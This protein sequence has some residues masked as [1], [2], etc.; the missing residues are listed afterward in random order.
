MDYKL[1][2]PLHRASLIGNVAS[3]KLLLSAGG[4]GN[5]RDKEGRTALHLA[6]QRVSSFKNNLPAGEEFQGW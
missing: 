1:R 3:V 6:C 4:E 5:A 2:T